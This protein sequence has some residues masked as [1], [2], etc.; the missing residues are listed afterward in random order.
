L[1]VQDSKGQTKWRRDDGEPRRT[2]EKLMQVSGMDKTMEQQNSMLL[3]SLR[4][5]RTN[6]SADTWKKLEEKMDLRQARDE[7]ISIYEAMYTL[8]EIKALNAFYSSPLGKKN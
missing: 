8:E 2:V 3:A 6:V 7:I 5:T 4:S 1:L